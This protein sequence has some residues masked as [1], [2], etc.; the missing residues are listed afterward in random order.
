MD[1]LADITYYFKVSI[2]DTTA[3]QVVAG[4]SFS[5]PRILK[6]G[7][8]HDLDF[9]AIDGFKVDQI[10]LLFSSD[11]G[12]YFE[13]FATMGD[14]TEHT[15]FA[16]SSFHNVL[17][18][19]ALQIK[20]IDYAGNSSTAES[21]YV[22]TI[23]SD[24]LFNTVYDGWNLWGAPITPDIDT[25]EVNLGD[26]FMGYWTTYDHVDN[27]YTYDGFLYKGEGYWLGTLENTEID[28]IGSPSTSDEEVSLTLGW[29]LLSN[30]LVLDVYVD[31]LEIFNSTTNETLLYPDAVDAGWVNSIYAYDGN[32]YTEPTVLKPWSGYWFSAL[33][34]NLSVIFPIHKH[35]QSVLPRD[36][37]EDGWGIQFFANTENGAED[38]LLMLGLHPEATD[39][40]DNGFDE[41]RP[42]SAPGS[43]YV[44]LD[45]LH[46][47]WDFPLGDSFVRDIRAENV[48]DGNEDWVVSVSSSEEFVTLSW[49]ISMIPEE[50]DVGIDLT[51]DGI[52]QDITIFET[53]TV[54]GGSEFTVRVGANVLALDNA[55]IPTEFMMNQNYPNPFN[56][57]TTINYGLPEVSDV[58]LV[59]YDIRGRQVNFWKVEQQPAGWYQV[60]WHGDNKYGKQ[61][62]TGMYFT[63]LQAG[64]YSKV[65]KMVYLR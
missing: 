27:G 26:D 13:P 20:A 16:P 11:S 42:P 33:Q 61:V 23:A 52:F 28:V 39:G 57:T 37:R 5:G 43:R 19:A 35:E 2:G 21:D 9:Q 25:M 34:T 55:A 30:P 49:D 51:G 17:Y 8:L 36:T 7:M 24:S 59:I 40:F 38:N 1:A 32:G 62:A 48:A 50:Y 54:P 41:V 56:P 53:I 60:N 4:R 46:A 64:D 45:I 6:S 65:I 47:D 18:G 15:W 31:S 58:S 63:R 29:D 10:D 22:L 14:T 3:P 44:Q 12:F